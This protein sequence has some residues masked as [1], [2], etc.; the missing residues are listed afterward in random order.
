[1]KKIRMF[2]AMAVMC[3]VL[4][5]CGSTVDVQPAIDSYNRLCDNYN[6][7]V[8]LGNESIDELDQETIDFF[9]DLVA[10]INEYGADFDNNK[11]FTQEEVDEMVEMFDELNDVIVDSLE[12]WGE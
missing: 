6:K 12:N 9:N 10:A 1:M 2:L 11:E 4:A 8:D 3:I 7:F 5:A